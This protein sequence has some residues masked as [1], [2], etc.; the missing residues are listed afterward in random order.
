MALERRWDNDTTGT[1]TRDASVA[2]PDV[3]RLLAVLGR[4]GWVAE[5]PE[6]HLLP[7]VVEAAERL[8]VTVLRGDVV[9]GVL[10]IDVGIAGAARRDIRAVVYSLIGA[11]AEAS[12]HVRETDGAFEVV[13]GMLSGDGEFATHGHLAR[14]RAVAVPPGD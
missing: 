12:T 6:H 1:G 7:H 10:E 3:E 13:T 4:D 9:A 5:A 11:F 8:G 14:I 2:A